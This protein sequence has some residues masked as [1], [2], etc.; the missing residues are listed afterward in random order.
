MKSDRCPDCGR[1]TSPSDPL[2]CLCAAAR[3]AGEPL[4]RE[5]LEDGAPARRHAEREA[6]GAHA[7]LAAI[8]RFRNIAEAGFFAEELARRNLP[9]SVRVDDQFDALHGHWNSSFLLLVP[10]ERGEAAAL[11][12]QE[13]I[14][15]SEQGEDLDDAPS[16]F[17]ERAFEEFGGHDRHDEWHAGTGTAG[18]FGPVDESRGATVRWVPLILTLTAGS[19][20]VWGLRHVEL[21]GAPPGAAP[22]SERE[23]NELRNELGTSERPWTQPTRDGQGLRKL[24]FDRDRNRV[25]IQ[26]EPRRS[27][28]PTTAAFV[29]AGG[30]ASATALVEE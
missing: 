16:E 20:I 11:L 5:P 24:W 12:L 22:L 6:G 4:E 15:R 26:V 28:S 29:A 21:F 9:A 8:A 23:W 30:A 2:G 7:P 27:P 3:S 14:R 10:A 1:S 13:L 18:D 17:D 25:A 19:V